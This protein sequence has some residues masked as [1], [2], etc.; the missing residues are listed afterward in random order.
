MRVKC[1]TNRSGYEYILTEGEEYEITDIQDAIFAGDYYVLGITDGG[2]KFICHLHRFD[3]SKETAE[4]Y[5]Q[6][7]H[8]DWREKNAT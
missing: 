6:E 7:H 3:I 8:A 2:Q 4:E 5:V 1:K